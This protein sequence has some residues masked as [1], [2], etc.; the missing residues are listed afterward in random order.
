MLTFWRQGYETSSIADLPAAMG[1]TAPSLYTAFGDKERLFLEAMRVYAGDPDALRSSVDQAPTA[2]HAASAMLRSAVVAFT[3]DD[4]PK[5]CLLASAAASGSDASAAVR[6]AMAEVRGHVGACLRARIER[7]MLDGALPSDIDAGATSGLVVGVIQ[8]LSVL[9]RD[10][11]PR[12][13]LMAIAEAAL[14]CWP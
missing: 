14:R 2:R 5:G 11:T 12:R 4:T 1:I 7:D 10:G 8:G 9:A 3:G 13:E 6:R